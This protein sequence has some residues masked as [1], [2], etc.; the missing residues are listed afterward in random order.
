MQTSQ[1]FDNFH[2]I[3]QCAQPVC[4]KKLGN[5][6]NFTKQDTFICDKC[7][8]KHPELLTD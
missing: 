4:N 8:H 3:G 7:A 2:N 5:S 6:W 1:Q